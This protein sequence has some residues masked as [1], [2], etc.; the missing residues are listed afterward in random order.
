MNL[1]CSIATRK[2]KSICLFLFFHIFNHRKIIGSLQSS[3]GFPSESNDK[4]IIIEENSLF[5]WWIIFH[6]CRR[7]P[8]F[9]WFFFFFFSSFF[10]TLIWFHSSNLFKAKSTQKIYR[11]WQAT[12]IPIQLC[13]QTKRMLY[14]F[15]FFFILFMHGDNFF[16]WFMV[17][18]RSDGDPFHA[19]KHSFENMKEF[20]TSWFM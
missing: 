12:M 13:N 3:I 11:L 15:F 6:C 17:Q 7:A 2:S 18:I 19:I 4:V 10:V 9:V 1:V 5:F 16:L 8:I 20:Q 14:P